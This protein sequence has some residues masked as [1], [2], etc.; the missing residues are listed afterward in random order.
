MAEGRTIFHL[1]TGPEWREAE[2]RGTYAA[3]SLAEVGFI[4]FSHAAQVARTA[5]ERFRDAPELVV[6]TVSVDDI[7]DD[8]LVA[9]PGDPG[10]PELFPHL[11]GALP[12]SAVRSVDPYEVP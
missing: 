12:T 8:A 10:S 7:G 4:P 3:P 1:T 5:R 6:L 9:E 2:A 11:Y